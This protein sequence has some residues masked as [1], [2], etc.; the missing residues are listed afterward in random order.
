MSKKKPDTIKT[1]EAYI[2]R[3]YGSQD[4]PRGRL[5]PESGN[6]LQNHLAHAYGLERVP[7]SE[8][9]SD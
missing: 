4:A 5:Q 2:K 8:A 9:E 7:E 6:P 3:T 1:L